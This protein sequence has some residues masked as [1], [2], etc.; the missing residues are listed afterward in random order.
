M[1]AVVLVNTI[2]LYETERI[3]H[4][5]WVADSPN[6]AWIQRPPQH[7]FDGLTTF[8]IGRGDLIRNQVLR[9]KRATKRRDPASRILSELVRRM[10]HQ[11]TVCLHFMAADSEKAR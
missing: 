9:L 6:K 1:T 3:A 10:Q 5:G 8:S 4:G 11:D 2:K 7:L